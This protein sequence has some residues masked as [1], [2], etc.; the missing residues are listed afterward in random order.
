MSDNLTVK[1][2]GQ[3]ITAKDYGTV[4]YNGK[5]LILVQD[6]YI[7]ETD[8]TYNGLIYQA[9]AVDP[10]NFDEEESDDHMYMVY[11]HVTADNPDE[12]EDE[13]DMCNWDEYEV[14]P[15]GEPLY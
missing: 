11:W 3:I 6:A 12:V 9:L 14:A 15:A 2:N 7:S 1:F 10:V 13:A 5:T 8:L 4:T